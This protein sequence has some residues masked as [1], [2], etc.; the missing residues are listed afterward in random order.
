MSDRWMLEFPAP[1][2]LLS[3]ND[4]GHWR[5]R[6]QLTRVWR[7]TAKLG[8]VSARNADRWQCP[9]PPAVVA[10][11][12]PVRDSRRRDPANYSATVKP[13]VD[14]L[15]DAGLRPDDTPEWVT[16]VEPIL[17]PDV[18]RRVR[19]VIVDRAAFTADWHQTLFDVLGG[20]SPC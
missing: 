5:R 6:H 20:G 7:H 10:V 19:V 17:V 3:M 4:R 11:G 15:V 1:G 14:G 9:L 2:A 13:I 12:L 8:A 18:A 16:T